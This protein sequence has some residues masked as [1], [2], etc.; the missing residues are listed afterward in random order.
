MRKYKGEKEASVGRL[1]EV[2]LPYDNSDNS[3][4]LLFSVMVA[5]TGLM[6][7]RTN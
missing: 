6:K 4:N 5:E 1:K 7:V 2:D 3:F